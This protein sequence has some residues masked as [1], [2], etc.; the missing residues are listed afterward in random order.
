MQ[1]ER[2]SSRERKLIRDLTLI[3]VIVLV[4]LSVFVLSGL[5]GE[6][7]EWVVVS[8]DGEEVAKYS[9]DVN[10]KYTLNGGTNLLVVSDGVAYVSEADCPDKVCVRTGKIS[11]SGERI[12]CLPNRLE[13]KVVGGEE[14]LTP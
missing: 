7:G 10:G 12:I 9:L 14:V 5:L 4:G 13:V 11:R 8:I 1:E 2:E 3:L 6:R